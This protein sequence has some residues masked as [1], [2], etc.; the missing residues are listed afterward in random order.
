MEEFEK[1]VDLHINDKIP[2]LMDIDQEKSQIGS[3]E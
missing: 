2:I 1:M 3:L